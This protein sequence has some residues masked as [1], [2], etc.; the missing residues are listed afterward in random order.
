M[1]CPYCASDESCA[2]HL[3]TVD[4]T[5]RMAAGGALHELFR[6]RWKTVRTKKGHERGDDFDESVDFEDCLAEV[7]AIA[8]YAEDEDFE[9][10]PGS[11]TI[12]RHF[13]CSMFTLVDAAVESYAKLCTTRAEL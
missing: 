9:G 12:L 3:L 11:S 7:E 1:A 6:T 5:E 10:G 8:T 4:I 2:H 13:Y